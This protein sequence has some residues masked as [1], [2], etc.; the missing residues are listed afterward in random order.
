MMKWHSEAQLG[1]GT[2]FE[3]R[4]PFHG[5]FGSVKHVPNHRIPNSNLLRSIQPHHVKQE[6]MAYRV[7][8]STEVLRQKSR[9]S[10]TYTILRNDPAGFITHYCFSFCWRAAAESDSFKCKP[11]T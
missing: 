11:M 8:V 4:Y 9:N 2:F 7:S 3:R 5:C 1:T 6:K 10:K